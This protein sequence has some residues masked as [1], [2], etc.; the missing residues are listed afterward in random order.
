VKSLL[1]TLTLF[2][3][4]AW[5]ANRVMARWPDDAA[6]PW[7]FGIGVAILILASIAV[8]VSGIERLHR[9]LRDALIGAWL[10][11]ALRKTGLYGPRLAGALRFFGYDP[12]PAHPDRLPQTRSR[13]SWSNVND[14][15]LLLGWI[16]SV[17]GLALIWAAV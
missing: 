3:A 1:M 10:G 9:A 15:V 16:G 11:Q 2:I 5:G 4:T 12:D 7:A 8:K 14:A 6:A 13:L 17:I